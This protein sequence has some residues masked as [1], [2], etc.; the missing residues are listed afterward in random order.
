VDAVLARL[1][2]V[3]G[4]L[5]EIRTISYSISPLYRYPSGQPPILTGY[6]ASNTVEVTT[7]DLSIIGRLI[8]AASQAGANQVHG[9]RF[10]LRNPE[11]LRAQALSAAAKQAR[12]HAE[13]IASG[14]GARLGTVITAQEGSA[15]V[16]RSPEMT[17]ADTR[18]TT[19]IETG[20]VDIQAT[21]TVEAEMI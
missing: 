2:S 14:L 12:A 13:A 11:P 10:G 21:V 18:V 9:L 5:G 17:T 6:T 4:S 3:L 16:I 20:T 1:R 19:P 8:D 15:V 7:R